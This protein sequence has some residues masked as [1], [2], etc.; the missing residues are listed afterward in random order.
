MA[1]EKE[2]EEYLEQQIKELDDQLKVL[3]DHMSEVAGVF[4][5]FGACEFDISLDST[6]LKIEEVQRRKKTVESMLA[7]LRE[8]EV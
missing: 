4:C 7:T 6:E 3:A 5:D 8:C 1:D 2:R